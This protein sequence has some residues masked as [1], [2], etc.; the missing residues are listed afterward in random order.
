M[1]Y[2]IL[3]FLLFALPLC[4]ADFSGKWSG[5]YDVLMQDG[6]AMKGNLVLTLAQSDSE[7]TGTVSSAE[8]GE[9][10]ISNGKADGDNVSFELHTEGP[11]MVFTLKLEEE[12]LR[13]EGKGD[14]EGIKVKIDLT[15][16]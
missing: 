12:H 6:Q 1:K 13:G 10:K 9:L 8:H 3:S 16:N 14:S 11:T 4:A 7:L 15:R 2:R 5:S